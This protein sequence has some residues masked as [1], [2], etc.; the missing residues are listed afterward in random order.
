M[1]ART[2]NRWLIGVIVGLAAGL[3]L[4]LWQVRPTYDLAFFLPAPE[5]EQEAVLVERLGQGA[6][7]RLMFIEITAQPGQDVLAQSAAVR[8][9]LA[10]SPLVLRVENG[11]RD[12][13]IDS[14]PASIWRWRYVLADADWSGGGLRSSL[15]DRVGDLTTLGGTEVA[16]LIANDPLWLA[17]RILEGL[18]FDRAA[19]G[20]RWFDGQSQAYLVAETVAAPFDIAAQRKAIDE[21]HT[22]YRDAGGRDA[23]LQLYGVGVYGARMQELIQRESQLLGIL[24]TLAVLTIVTLAYRSTRLTLLSAI[25]LAAAVLGGLIVSTAVYG[26]IHGITIAFGATL[27]GVV[28][29]Y[30]MHLFS[31]ARHVAPRESVRLLFRTLLA[32][33]GTA[34]VA[35]AALV[36]SGSRGLAQLGLFSLTGIACAM[37]VTCWVLPHLMKSAPAVPHD[38]VPQEFRLS[39]RVWLPLLVFAIAS[40]FAA[41]GVRWNDNLG[42]VTPLPPSLLARDNAMRQRFGAPDVRYLISLT[43]DSEDAA[44][45]ST[46]DLERR[47]GA[48]RDAGLLGTWSA[49]TA[50]LPSEATQ[51]RRLAAIP[52]A[53]ELHERVREAAQGLP[54]RRDAFEPFLAGAAEARG[55]EPLHAADLADGF[56]GDFVSSHLAQSGSRWRSVVFVTGLAAPAQLTAWL[57]KQAPGAELV[58]LKAA[59]ESLVRGYRVHLITILAAA[60]ALIAVLILWSTGSASRFIWSIGTVAASVVFTLA[61]VNWLHGSVSVFHMVSLVLVAGLGVD[62][63]LFYSRPGVSRTEFL[64]TRHAVMACASST[65]GA[66]AILGTSSIPLLGSIGT[67]VGIGTALMFVVARFGCQALPPPA[68]TDSASSRALSSFMS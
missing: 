50:L 52:P 28:D 4:V 54:F 65:A 39:A 58:D 49:V 66:F 57:A 19:S 59:S 34:I 40:T 63:C 29:D 17:P 37:A 31:H 32:S 48:A 35:Y 7:A 56:A 36:F 2:G 11:Q 44:L 51:K 26:S 14:I 5:T 3:G 10:R 43:A 62:Y 1:A 13:S 67:T 61:A 30:P 18:Q 33:A 46:E 24:A 53:D 25:P 21:V 8:E 64:D 60:T 15:T 23:G 45:A 20:P 41:G 16:R 12:I 6:G 9:R 47:L 38:P 27:V 22:A 55:L 42:D 68:A